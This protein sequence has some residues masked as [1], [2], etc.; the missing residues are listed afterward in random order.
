MTP[1]LRRSLR[2][3]KAALEDECTLVHTSKNTV[4]APDTPLIG[5]SSPG[6]S[7]LALS[8]DILES[9]PFP[10]PELDFLDSQFDSMNFISEKETRG[11]RGA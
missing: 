2:S 9:N 6:P 10:L 7:K 5:F 4:V 1:K 11:Y 3:V 8:D